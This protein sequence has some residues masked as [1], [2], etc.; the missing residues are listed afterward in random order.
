MKCVAYL[1][2][3]EFRGS[4]GAKG[5][6]LSGGVATFSSCCSSPASL[7][8]SIALWL[9]ICALGVFAVLLC[10]EMNSDLTP[11]RASNRAVVAPEGPAPMI[12]TG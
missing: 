5:Q 7:R 2:T 8:T 10:L 3:S 9:N 1:E 11:S 12:R 6:L 4:F